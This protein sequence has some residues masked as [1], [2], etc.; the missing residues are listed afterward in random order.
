MSEYAL[1]RIWETV[2]KDQN[3]KSIQSDNFFTVNTTRVEGTRK[4]SRLQEKVQAYLVPSF[5]II[6]VHVGNIHK[7]QLQGNLTWQF[8]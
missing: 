6:K 4:L 2:T 5:D 3:T 7:V 8:F 1:E